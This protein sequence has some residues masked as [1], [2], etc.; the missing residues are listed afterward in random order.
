MSLNPVIVG[1]GPAGM[2]A[3]IELAEHGVHSTLVEEASRLGGVVYRG[4]LRDGVQLDY[5]GP[6]YCEVL[7]KLHGAF[8]D[9]EQMIDVRLN[10]R[11]IGA[12]GSHSLMLLDAE[13]QVQEVPYGQ[14]VLAA[15]CHERSVPFPGWTLP[16]VKLLGG[17]QL[18]IK[19]GVVKPQSPVVIA[20]TGPCCRWWRASCTLPGC[21][22]PG[23]TRPAPWARSPS[24]AW[25]CSTSRNCS[26]TA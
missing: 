18:Q 25:P 9:H 1:G 24:R 3:A 20:G 23:S 19:S 21:A 7:A 15:G 2:A 22:W 11:V 5:L 14:L 8:G 13:E 6:R 16:G 12:E 17:L 26:S 4:P 10:S